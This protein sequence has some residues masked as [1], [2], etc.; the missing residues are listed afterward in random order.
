MDPT[1]PKRIPRCLGTAVSDQT[2]AEHHRYSEHPFFPNVDNS[3]DTV[4]LETSPQEPMCMAISC[5]SGP[6]GA[7]L[8]RGRTEDRRSIT[9]SSPCMI[10]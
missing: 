4:E 8:H 7:V 2:G 1:V 6:D 9:T 3:V 10:P 5:H